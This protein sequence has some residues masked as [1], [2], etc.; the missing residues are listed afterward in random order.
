[1]FFV[2]VN[3]MREIFHADV[4]NSFAPFYATHVRASF[5]ANDFI[6]FFW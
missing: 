1:M 6:L 2:Y 3:L 4:F 5:F